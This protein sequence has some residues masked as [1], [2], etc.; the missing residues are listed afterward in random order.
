MS[1]F[2]LRTKSPAEIHAPASAASGSAWSPTPA[3]SFPSS[4]PLAHAR[5]SATKPGSGG[6]V[7][8]RP[9]ACFVGGQL[10]RDGLHAGPAL[11]QALP[12]PLPA[13]DRHRGPRAAAWLVSENR[14]EAS[15]VRGRQTVQ[16]PPLDALG[17]QEILLVVEARKALP[18]WRQG[19]ALHVT[20]P[21]EQSEHPV[22]LPGERLAPAC[23]LAF[24][25]L[26]LA[27]EA[28]TARCST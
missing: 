22:E 27:G 12:R 21:F 25:P 8:G 14:G 2:V 17:D 24:Q 10:R 5:A 6:L 9:K 18:R 3:T 11:A 23:H 28:F 26:D 15:H 7:R 4:I 19:P 1:C 13:G 16:Q 20:P